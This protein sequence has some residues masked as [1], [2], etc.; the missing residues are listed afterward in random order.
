MPAYTVQLSKE[1]LR[2][3][4]KQDKKT[5]NRIM[6][7]IDEIANDPYASNNNVNKLKGWPGYRLRV[8]NIRVLYELRDAVLVVAVMKIGFRGSVYQGKL[9]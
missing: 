1:A 5:V 3:L 9:I 4:E 7:K 6:A 8:G 2:F